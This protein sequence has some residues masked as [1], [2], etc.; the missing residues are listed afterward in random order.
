MAEKK[1][2]YCF[3]RAPRGT[4]YWT[5]GFRAA[6]G[7]VAGVDEHKVDLLF[8]GDGVY[9]ALKDLDRTENSGYIPTLKESGA[10]FYVVR[11]DLEEKGISREEVAC[12]FELIDRVAALRLLKEADMTSDW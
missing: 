6:V 8:S 1:I 2:I 9:H 4:I 5:E 11:E 7:A 12:D 10:K 3:M